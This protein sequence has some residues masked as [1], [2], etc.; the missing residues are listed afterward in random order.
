MQRL[1]IVATAKRCEMKLRKFK[2]DEGDNGISRIVNSIVQIGYR[3]GVIEIS[4]E[5][6]SEEVGVFT[7]TRREEVLEKRLQIN[8]PLYVHKPIVAHLRSMAALDSSQN[9][10]MVEARL[11]D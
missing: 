3:D 4:F 9:K 2:Y 7:K 5:P 11:Q 6:T 1:E 10:G 8:L